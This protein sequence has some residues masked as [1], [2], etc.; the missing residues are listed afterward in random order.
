MPRNLELK[1]TNAPTFHT[2]SVTELFTGPV[3]RWGELGR[4]RWH[5]E[6]PLAR[7]GIRSC[8]S[9]DTQ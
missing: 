1:V 9:P 6:R 8:A 4:G 3:V 2:W 5:Q 7:G